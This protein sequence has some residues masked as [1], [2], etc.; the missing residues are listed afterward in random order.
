[1]LKKTVCGSGKAETLER[2]TVEGGG[3]FL[4]EIGGGAPKEEEK[5][6]KRER[7]TV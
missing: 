7:R 4:S 5:R 3:R 6:E 2:R 1:L